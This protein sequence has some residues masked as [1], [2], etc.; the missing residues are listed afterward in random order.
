MR[1]ARGACSVMPKTIVLQH[2]PHAYALAVQ[3]RMSVVRFHFGLRIDH[4]DSS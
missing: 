4:R 3:Q 2:H 1:A